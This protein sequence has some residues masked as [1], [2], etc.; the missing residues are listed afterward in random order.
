MASG[1]DCV[2]GEVVL[3]LWRR[4]DGGVVAAMV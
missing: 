1:V 3:E 2:D 4:H